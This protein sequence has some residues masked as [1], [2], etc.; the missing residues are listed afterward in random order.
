MSKVLQFIKECFI[1]G[2]RIVS[3]FV[4]IAAGAILLSGSIVAIVQPT[5]P[6]TVKLPLIAL[7]VFIAGFVSRFLREKF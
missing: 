1:D 4:V 6:L 2:L 7:I 3:L 5:V